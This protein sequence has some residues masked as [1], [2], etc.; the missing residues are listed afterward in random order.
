MKI[1][2][3]IQNNSLHDSFIINADYIPDNKILKLNIVQL[4]SELSTNNVLNDKYNPDD[5]VEVEIIFSNIKY[6]CPGDISFI[7]YEILSLESGKI[8]NYD[9]ILIQMITEN[10]YREIYL[11]GENINIICNIIKKYKF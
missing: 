5:Q 3:F 10:D 11:R 8:N 1:K 4:F 7:G 6:Q 9:I 2:D